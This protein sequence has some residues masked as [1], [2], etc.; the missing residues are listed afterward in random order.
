VPKRLKRLL[1]SLQITQFVVGASYAFLHLFIK[2]QIPVSVPYLYHVA[3]KIASMVAS[4][5]SSVAAA[6]VA[7]ATA[8]PRAFWKKFALRAAGYEG[9]AE[10]V[11]VRPYGANGA[12][13]AV[14]NGTPV[15]PQQ[16]LQQ[17]EHR[18]KDELQWVHCLDTSGQVF[19][20]LLNVLYL[21][22]LTWLFAR[23]FVKAYLTQLERR[24]SSGASDKVSVGKSLEDATKGATRRVSQ[25]LMEM[26]NTGD[27]SENE[28]PVVESDETI[29]TL[30]SK[31]NALAEDAGKTAKAA[32]RKAGDIAASVKEDLAAVAQKVADAKKSAE[33]NAKP[34]AED[35]GKKAADAKKSVENNAKP[36]AEDVSKKADE[37]AAKLKEGSSQAK[38][39]SQAAGNAASEATEDK[40]YADAVKE[41]DESDTKKDKKPASSPPNDDG[42]GADEGSGSQ[43]K[44]TEHDDDSAELGAKKEEEKILDESKPVREDEVGKQ[45]QSSS[46][47]RPK[48]LPKK[49]A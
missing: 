43:N 11:G 48:K 24:R 18:Y 1:T 27:S 25:A 4:D 20:I 45:E 44:G 47:P 10:N 49:K 3:P 37:A 28:S 26:H 13:G 42:T 46:L 15:V 22:P 31:A 16:Y 14:D 30:K 33:K 38:E 41:E 21:A 2:Y 8:D 7:S 23:F 34:I 29:N 19:A 39:Q 36:I 12:Y 6:A 5:A 35:A 32:Q 9:L 40:S 17:A